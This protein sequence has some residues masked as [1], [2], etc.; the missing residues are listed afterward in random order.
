MFNDFIIM[1]SHECITSMSPE[2]IFLGNDL[3]MYYFSVIE[4][5][6]IAIFLPVC[7]FQHDKARV[8][9][10][11]LFVTG[12]NTMLQTLFGTRLPTVIGGS[13]AFLVPVISIIRDPSLTQIADDHTVSMQS[14]LILIVIAHLSDTTHMF[15]LIAEV[16]N[17]H[18]GHTGG[19]DNFVLHSDNTWLQ[20][21]MGDMLQVQTSH[22]FNCCIMSTNVQTLACPCLI[23]LF[24]P[25][26]CM[27]N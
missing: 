26:R 6:L 27:A 8:V 16:Q 19:S 23:L 20:P 10:T 21:I 1:R 2:F 15:S 5:I 9:Q 13:Y 7:C 17:D 3:F 12:I 22:A 18:E 4:S 14:L 11:V 25:L 24:C